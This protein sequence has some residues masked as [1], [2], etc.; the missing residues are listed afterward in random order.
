[1]LA[2]LPTSELARKANNVQFAG[3]VF[4]YSEDWR[5]F[6]VAEQESDESWA[7]YEVRAGAPRVR[8]HRFFDERLVVIS[9]NGRW[10]VTAREDRVRLWDLNKDVW[11]P[12]TLPNQDHTNTGSLLFSPDERWLLMQGEFDGFRIW[13]T[14]APAKSLA[15]K[16]TGQLVEFIFSPDGRWMAALDTSG[17]TGFYTLGGTDAPAP[18]NPI[19]WST[20]I[21]AVHFSADGRWIYA[22]SAGVGMGRLRDLS[23]DYDGEF[24]SVSDKGEILRTIISGPTT[25]AGF[26]NDSRWLLTTDSSSLGIW[27]LHAQGQK[28]GPTILSEEGIEVASLDAQSKRLLVTVPGRLITWELP[29]LEAS[30]QPIRAGHDGKRINGHVFSR[31]ARWLITTAEGDLPRLWR[32]PPATTA[33]RLGRVALPGAAPSA[34]SARSFFG[35]ASTCVGTVDSVETLRIWALPLDVNSAARLVTTIASANLVETDPQQSMIAIAGVSGAIV[36]DVRAEEMQARVRHLESAAEGISSFQYSADSRWLL[37]RSSESRT[38]QLWDLRAEGT[39]LL[40][41]FSVSDA[42]RGFIGPLG[43]WIVALSAQPTGSS[44]IRAWRISER[45]AA[46]PAVDYRLEQ[47]N[48]EVSVSSDEKWL[49]A[50]DYPEPLLWHLDAE[51]SSSERITNVAVTGP[52]NDLALSVDNRWLAV[53]SEAGGIRITDLKSPE[54]ATQHLTSSGHS[55]M[56]SANGERLF[57]GEH[58]GVVASVSDGKWTSQSINIHTKRPVFSTDGRWLAGPGADSVEDLVSGA[59]HSI[60]GLHA[61]AAEQPFSEDGRWLLARDGG[62]LLCDLSSP[63]ATNDNLSCEA[64]GGGSIDGVVW[65]SRYA[66][67]RDDSSVALWVLAPD[68]LISLARR[69]LSRDLTKAE[70]EQFLPGQPYHETRKA[71]VKR[72]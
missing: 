8:R 30:A 44:R 12:V 40:P 43:Q 71:A 1:M 29:L 4:Y 39:R 5:W 25:F 67:G 18:A 3:A 68:D 72:Q 51:T 57:T 35:C 26:S 48:P 14:G 23:R 59:W 70:W 54:L 37:A 65:G 52:A 20:D 42:K 6:A 33:G 15:A 10:L 9:P 11:N 28:F 2:E 24:V 50:E 61:G 38:M 34:E 17:E 19:R 49:L 41:I 62:A 64:L 22:E 58:S 60:P 55:L 46:K 16:T 13:N 27:D 21:R 63:T 45:M 32:I 36:V 31:D 7:L 47:S 56:F 66:Y 69:S 53:G